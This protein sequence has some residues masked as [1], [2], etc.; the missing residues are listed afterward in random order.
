M[1]LETSSITL[2]PQEI[3]V[4]GQRE[5]GKEIRHRSATTGGM[6]GEYGQLG[7]CTRVICRLLSVSGRGI[8]T[9]TD[10]SPADH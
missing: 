2:K 8:L 6:V 4:D 7:I 10:K 3:I 1:I 5:E 9:L